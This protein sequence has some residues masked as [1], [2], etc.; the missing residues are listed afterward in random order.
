M[1]QGFFYFNKADRRVIV[2]LG[3]VAVVV[4]AVLLVVKLLWE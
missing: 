4:C 3:A 2:V 1:K